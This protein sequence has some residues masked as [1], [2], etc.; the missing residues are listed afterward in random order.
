MNNP[1]D[2]NKAYV[3][4]VGIGN[5]DVDSPA[6]ATTANDARRVAKELVGRARFLPANVQT[7]LN[8]DATVANV[9]GKL[10]SLAETTK[11]TPAEMVI[12]YFSGHG[13][14]KNDNYYIVCRDTIN[15]DVENTAIK[16]S[17]FVEK[18]K[19]IQTDKM[20]ILLD[21][22]HSGG[23]YD[24]I[25]IPFDEADVLKMKNR[26]IISASK[27]DN[28]SFLSKPLSIFTYALVE[29]LAGKYFSGN[30]TEVTLFNLAMYLR[31]RV[32][33]LSGNRQQPQLNI[34]RDSLTSDFVIARYPNGDPRPA[35]FDEDFSLL[36]S[37][38]KDI[39]TSIEPVKDDSYRKEFEWMLNVSGNNNTI[40]A[41]NTGSIS[42]ETT[43][44]N[45]EKIVNMG[46]VSG[47]TFNF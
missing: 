44:Q 3:L 41:G 12:I 22:C 10:D 32:F 15:T 20:L 7:V 14:V 5:R 11:N 37:E 29:G 39:D 25:D 18:L 23:M 2:S 35:A 34:L 9:I 43:T 30:D 4:S 42:I 19:S 26:V 45:A 17:V 46:D 6:M 28:V 16:G 21:C 13:C 8:S 31:E 27:A 38:G 33:P 1:F 36:T 47:S 40:I 24:P